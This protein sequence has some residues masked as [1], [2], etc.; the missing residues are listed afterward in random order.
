MTA[1]TW[2]TV[3]GDDEVP[4]QRVVIGLALEARGVTPAANRDEFDRTRLSPSTPRWCEA[5]PVLDEQLAEHRWRI[6][7]LNP[8]IEQKR[9]AVAQ[10]QSLDDP[11]HASSALDGTPSA[12]A[13]ILTRKLKPH[14]RANL[15]HFLKLEAHPAF[16]Q[17]DAVWGYPRMR[18]KE[19]DRH[20]RGHV[21]TGKPPSFLKERSHALILSI[22]PDRRNE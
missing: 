16:A 18:L 1:E 2:R 4:V 3:D 15:E 8:H 10:I 7:K 14:H 9:R 11:R 19:A 6:D 5:T 17:V 20:M 12:D 22:F 21:R 13:G